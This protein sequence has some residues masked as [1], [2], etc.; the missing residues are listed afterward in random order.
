MRG[1]KTYC[2]SCRAGFQIDRAVDAPERTPR[3]QQFPYQ[4]IRR[5]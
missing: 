5:T 4:S 3:A 1:T 2:S